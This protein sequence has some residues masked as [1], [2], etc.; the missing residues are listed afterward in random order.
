MVDATGSLPSAENAMQQ[1]Q[2][3][4]DPRNVRPQQH[5]LV[6]HPSP[7]RL[8]N[9]NNRNSPNISDSSLQSAD[10]CDE[11]PHYKFDPVEARGALMQDEQLYT[12]M[13]NEQG[14][15]SLRSSRSP[16]SPIVSVTFL[17]C[18]QQRFKK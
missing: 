9:A 1:Q 4:Q 18:L 17:Y 8:Q 12:I 16:S 6:A 14:M 5:Q 10:L 2:H 13:T 3:Q 11:F 7:L 15:V